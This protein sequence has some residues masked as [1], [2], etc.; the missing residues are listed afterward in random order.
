MTHF[1]TIAWG[2]LSNTLC[3]C[4]MLPPVKVNPILSFTELEMIRLLVTSSAP[5]IGTW[6]A[7]LLDCEC[8][9]SVGCPG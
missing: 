9:E 4:L 7:L 8:Q 3:A 1:E 2:K 6:D 5:E